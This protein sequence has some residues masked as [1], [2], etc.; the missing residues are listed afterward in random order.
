MMHQRDWFAAYCAMPEDEKEFYREF[1]MD[2]TD[3]IKLNTYKR[4]YDTVSLMASDYENQITA[5]PKG[6]DIADEIALLFDDEVV[7]AM[8]A[9]Y[10]D[11]MLSIEACAR[12]KDIDNTLSEMGKQKDESLWTLEALEQSELWEKCREDAKQLLLL[13]CKL[14]YIDYG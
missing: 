7:A 5:L 10:K 9:L 6:I 2:Q 1:E 3:K 11:G 14:E 12:I 13:L 4:M 8:D